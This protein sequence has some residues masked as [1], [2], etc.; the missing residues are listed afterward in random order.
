[1]DFFLIE[2]RTA[3]DLELRRLLARIRLEIQDRSDV[4]LLNARCYQEGRRI[5][6][7]TGITVVTPLNRNRWN[8]NLEATLAFQ[9]Q[10]KAT[11]RIF[12]SN[13]KWKDSQP[14]E[15]EALMVLNHRD[16]SAIPV[17]AVFM[18]VP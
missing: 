1:M 2:V 15:E 5:P 16:D 10:H 8:L 17:P 11:L 13:H 9:Q 3:G 14:T 4:D 18:F 7:E 12:I 6:W